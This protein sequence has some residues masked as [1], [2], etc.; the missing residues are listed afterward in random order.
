MRQGWLHDKTKK[1]IAKHKLTAVTGGNFTQA[2][3]KNKQVI[4]GDDSLLPDMIFRSQAWN[5][6]FSLCTCLS[7]VKARWSTLKKGQTDL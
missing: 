3:P 5:A 2:A 6:S 4:D 1:K 7:S